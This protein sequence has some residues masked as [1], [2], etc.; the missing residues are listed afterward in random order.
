MEKRFEAKTQELRNKLKES[1]EINKN[2]QNTVIKTISIDKKTL[3]LA[4]D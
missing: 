3:Y 2:I 1:L 4:K